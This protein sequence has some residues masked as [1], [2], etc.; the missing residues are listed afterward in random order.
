MTEA[1]MRAKK[2]QRD[3]VRVPGSPMKVAEVL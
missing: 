1:K 2:E 3:A